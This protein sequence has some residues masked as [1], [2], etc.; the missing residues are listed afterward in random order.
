L[1][2]SFFLAAHLL[3]GG[4]AE[5]RAPQVNPLSFLSTPDT[6]RVRAST[7]PATGGLIIEFMPPSSAANTMESTAETTGAAEEP[8]ALQADAQP[9]PGDGGEASAAQAAATE[10]PTVAPSTPA[11]EPTPVPTE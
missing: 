7:L 3:G 6:T 11:P 8:F 4:T 10:E 1:S 9:A 5:V 2:I